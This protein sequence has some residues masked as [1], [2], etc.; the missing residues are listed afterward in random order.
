DGRR[1]VPYCH[2]PARAGPEALEGRLCA[3]LAPAQGWALWREPQPAAAL[4]SVPGDPEALAGQYPAALSRFSGRHRAR[5]LGA[6]YS[7][8]RRRLGKPDIR[9]LGPGLGMLVRWDG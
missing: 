8:C 1:H 5:R 7:V 3:T 2:D 4:L 6:R 9:R